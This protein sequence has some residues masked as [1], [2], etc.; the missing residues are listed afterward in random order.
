MIVISSFGHKEN[1]DQAV[2]A[3]FCIKRG[4]KIVFTIVFFEV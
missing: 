1:T 3:R 2:M 4:L